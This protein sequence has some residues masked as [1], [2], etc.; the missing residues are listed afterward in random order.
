[1]A[2]EE[3]EHDS[4]EE[5]ENTAPVTHKTKKHVESKKA[6]STPEPE[7]DE[8]DPPS[9]MSRIEALRAKLHA[10]LAEKRAQRPTDPNA[11]SKR[12]ARRAEKAK[13]QEDAKSRRAMTKVSDRTKQYKISESAATKESD[14]QGLDFGKLAGL[15]ATPKNFANNKSLSNINKKKNL[16]KMLADAEAK[17][18]KLDELK[19]GSEEEKAKAQ[20]MAWS[21]ALKEAGGERIKDDPTKLKKALKRKEAKKAKSAKAWKSRMEQTKSKMDE[22]QQIRNHNLNKRKVGGATGANLSNKRIVDK[23]AEEEEKKTRK[24]RAGFEGKK[25]GFLNNQKGKKKGTT[26]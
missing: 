15:N 23:E 3:E 17:K 1:M 6:P 8:E 16:Q 11:V 24:G 12:A 26:Q 7:H 20:E 18:Q 14:L 10:K 2:K 9:S 21:A 22:R 4:E 25:Q 19:K 13:R 5:E